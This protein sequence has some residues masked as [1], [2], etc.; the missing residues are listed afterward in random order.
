MPTMRMLIGGMDFSKSSCEASGEASLFQRCLI[1]L[2]TTV[3]EQMLSMA[4]N[5]APATHRQIF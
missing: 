4:I 5:I 3:Y 1:H 2:F